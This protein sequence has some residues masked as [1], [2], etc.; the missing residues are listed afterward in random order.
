MYYIAR[1]TGYNLV[2]YI[3]YIVIDFLSKVEQCD[4]VI[5]STVRPHR[6]KFERT[7]CN[8]AVN[9]LAV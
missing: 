6:K 3:V 8:V 7:L 2:A 1:V 4:S 9:A 5:T